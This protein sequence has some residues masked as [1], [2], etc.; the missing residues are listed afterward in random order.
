MENILELNS[1]S[2]IIF[3]ILVCFLICL[4]I[5]FYGYRTKIIVFIQINS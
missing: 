2:L 1:V 4:Y 3:P 5:E